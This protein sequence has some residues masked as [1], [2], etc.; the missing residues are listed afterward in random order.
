VSLVEISKHQKKENVRVSPLDENL[1]EESKG[2]L[3]T[4]LIL[5]L[6]SFHSRHLSQKALAVLVP[7]VL[8]R[9]Q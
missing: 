6:T 5:C 1:L 3:L 2:A 8:I 7:F 4:I 9:D